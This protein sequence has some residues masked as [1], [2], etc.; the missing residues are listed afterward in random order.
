MKA[1]EIQPCHYCNREMQVGALSYQEHPFCNECLADR[2]RAAEI[3]RGP[4]EWVD[5]GRYMVL[6]PQGSRI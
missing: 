3:E 2:L 5:E 6:K 1:K 4:M